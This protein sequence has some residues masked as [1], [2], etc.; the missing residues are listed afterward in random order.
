MLKNWIYLIN[1]K[2]KELIYQTP[3]MTEDKLLKLIDNEL[4][5]VKSSFKNRIR[6]LHKDINLNQ[7]FLD[8]Y[9]LIQDKNSYLT[10]SQRD[11]VVGLVGYCMI[12][13]VKDDRSSGE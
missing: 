3:E 9:D 12:N 13:M 8:E 5:K 1:M 10:K 7:A 11:F 4:L 6:G 2:V